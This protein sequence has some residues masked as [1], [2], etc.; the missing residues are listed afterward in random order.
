M[1]TMMKAE[2]LGNACDDFPTSCCIHIVGYGVAGRAVTEHL[3]ATSNLADIRV[4]GLTP[5]ENQW[6]NHIL[7]SDMLFLV[8]DP[9][10]GDDIQQALALA[11]RAKK[12]G[13]LTFAICY[14]QKPITPEVDGPWRD[15][16]I[17]KDSVDALFVVVAEQSALQGAANTKE[18]IAA[19]MN[20]NCQTIVHSIGN[21]FAQ[22]G[23]VAIDFADIRTIF[24][25]SGYA[26]IGVGFGWGEAG[27]TN[28]ATSAIGSLI[29]RGIDVTKARGALVTISAHP[30]YFPLDLFSDVMDVCDS[31]LAVDWNLAAG[32]Y[33]DCAR[34]DDKVS[35]YLL[36]TGVDKEHAVLPI[37]SA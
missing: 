10:V 18:R 35:V 4:F 1:N 27:G 33:L 20:V 36:V 15:L 16:D 6:D 14:S 17:L 31:T 34:L 30:Q 13:A 9:A 32:T 19:L 24:Q 5:G 7:E 2:E 29:R 21:L 37:P 25:N 3:K 26:V 8:V 12:E 22:R 28:A 11:I 23:M